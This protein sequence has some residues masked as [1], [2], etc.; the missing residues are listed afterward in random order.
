MLV[1]ISL[2]VLTLV[3]ALVIG[4]YTAKKRVVD[5]VEPPEIRPD[6]PPP[7]PGPRGLEQERPGMHLH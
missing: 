6:D 7:P 1:P 4:L 2:L 3:A 5:D